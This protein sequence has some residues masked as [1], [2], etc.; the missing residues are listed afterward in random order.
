MDQLA[1]PAIPAKRRVHPLAKWSLIVAVGTI[2]VSI[3]SVAF[4]PPLIPAVAGGGLAAL[5]AIGGIIGTLVR[6]RNFASFAMCI[7][8]GFV[9][10]IVVLVMLPFV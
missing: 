8:G 3:I 10:A 2:P 7:G 9:A 6:S 5:L 1:M 4:M